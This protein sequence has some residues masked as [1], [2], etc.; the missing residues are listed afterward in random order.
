[1]LAR[2]IDP[3]YDDADDANGAQHKAY[4]Q[5]I[6]HPVKPGADDF[7]IEND[8]ATAEVTDSIHKIKEEPGIALYPEGG[9]KPVEEKALQ[10]VIAYVEPDGIYY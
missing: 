1:M 7:F 4:L 5:K 8:K 6:M 9:N 2:K 10:G 3:R